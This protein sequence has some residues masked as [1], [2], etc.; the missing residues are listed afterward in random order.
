ME[1]QQFSHADGLQPAV[2]LK[3]A[4]PSA[5]KKL[6]VFRPSRPDQSTA[7]F[8]ADLQTTAETPLGCD[9]LDPRRL[10]FSRLAAEVIVGYLIQGESMTFISQHLRASFPKC[11]PCPPYRRIVNAI[12]GYPEF[13]AIVDRAKNI[14]AD[15]IIARARLTARGY[16]Q[17]YGGYST[18]DIQRDKLIVDTELKFAAKLAP[19]RYGDK[20]AVNMEG[21]IE[22]QHSIV[23]MGELQRKLI[24]LRR[25]EAQSSV[26]AYEQQQPLF[27]ET[28]QLPAPVTFV[29]SRNPSKDVV[30]DADLVIAPA[31]DARLLDGDSGIQFR[32]NS[33][34]GRVNPAEG[35]NPYDI[36]PELE[37]LAKTRS[38][39][40]FSVQRAAQE[41]QLDAVCVSDMAAK[42]LANEKKDGKTVDWREERRQ[43]LRELE[44]GKR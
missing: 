24:D 2:D 22:H 31:S 3:L 5:R 7:V 4:S 16:A 18:G 12:C 39:K 19:E 32:Q 29:D 44:A 35:V 28:A 10:G 15:A 14:G 38:P 34:I 43:R 20:V 36:P 13:A 41:G 8:G 27:P 33:T 25:Q 40:I 21:K 6:R 1:N 23:M 9:K 42:R 26:D 17:H 37:E 30:V 11:A